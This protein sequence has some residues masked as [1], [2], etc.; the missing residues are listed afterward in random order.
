[1]TPPQ[2][3][4][5]SEC[6]RQTSPE[7]LARFGDRLVCVNCKDAYAQKLR[8]GVPPV[9]GFRYGGF[10]LR[11]VGI[12]IDGV[13]LAI[14]V[15]ILEF[16]LAAAL[17]MN[18]TRVGPNPSP[19]EVFAMLGPLM[20]LIGLVWLISMAIGVTYEGFFLSK[21]GATPGK[22][23]IGV[24]VV[25]PD[26]SGITIGRAVGRY[27]ARM[28]SGIILYIGFIMAGFD[29]Q[30]RALHDRICDTLVVKARS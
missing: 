14:P 25:R 5:C 27:F 6:G 22:M 28:L 15:L 2:V 3:Y 19:D 21:F 30:K 26:G 24:K 12:F 7:Q 10:W 23:A 4:Y 11:L 29:P 20:G 16:V 13:I 17:G 9:T 1:M 18:V 8:E